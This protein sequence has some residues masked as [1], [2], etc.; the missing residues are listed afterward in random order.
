MAKQRPTRR[1]LE[2]LQAYVRAGSVA[3]AADDLGVSETTARQRR[4]PALPELPDGTCDISAVDE[5]LDGE[6]ST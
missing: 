3:A 6:T 4:P 2:V 5:T 1:Q